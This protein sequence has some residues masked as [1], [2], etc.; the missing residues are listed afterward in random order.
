MQLAAMTKPPF[1]DPE[2]WIGDF[3]DEFRSS[4]AIPPRFLLDLDPCVNE[5]CPRSTSVPDATRFGR[6]AAHLPTSLLLSTRHGKQAD[7]TAHR[8]Q[9]CD[10]ALSAVLSVHPATGPAEP[11]RPS[12]GTYYTPCGARSGDHYP[13]RY[14]ER[15][16]CDAEAGE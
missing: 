13:R 9:R 12:P 10:I 14:I 4:A 6:L 3:F 11:R 15:A 5:G 7:H 1:F 2:T 16:G 8:D